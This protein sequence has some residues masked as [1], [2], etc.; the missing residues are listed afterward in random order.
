MAHMADEAIRV[1]ARGVVRRNG[2]NRDPALSENG[3]ELLVARERDAD[4]EPF[5]C[6]LG[7]GVEFGEH[8]ADALRR[9]FDEE[10]GVSLADA[11]YRETYESVFTHGGERHHELWRTYDVVVAAS[12]PYE[13]DAFPA[14][15]PDLDE[16]MR[17]EWKPVDAFVD[18][19]ETLYPAALL[20]DR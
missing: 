20:D 14:Y 17:C 6:P 9:E 1:V 10:L 7:G 8:G 16:Q 13:R 12:W 19:D 15:E 11:T 4:G 18:G 5:Y 2:A 3:T